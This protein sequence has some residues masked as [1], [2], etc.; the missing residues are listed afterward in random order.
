MTSR[1]SW[2]ATRIAVAIAIGFVR[3]GA[4]I[5]DGPATSEAAEAIQA[6]L[7]VERALLREDL[8]RHERLAAER[9]KAAARLVETYVEL[10]AALAKS[11]PGTH[12]A[13][14][15]PRAKVARAEAARQELSAQEA[16]LLDKV[17]DHMRRIR[18]LEEKLV[19]FPERAQEVG[20]PLSGRWDV[21]LLPSG[22]TGVFSLTQSG[23]LISGTYQLEGGWSGSLQG[24]LVNRKVHLERIDSKQGRSGEFEGFLSSDGSRI[25]GT[26][27]SY[28]L[29]ARDPASGQ[30]SAARRA[31]F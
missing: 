9:S 18:L 15:E 24:T 20:G 27:R 12:K 6:T 16:T 4:Q 8:E 1:V 29:S 30:W 19:S 31:A 14:D 10:D 22:I 28:E 5:D 17:Q 21:T 2:L 23:T 13:L 26:W 25:R 7:E 11:E 3:A